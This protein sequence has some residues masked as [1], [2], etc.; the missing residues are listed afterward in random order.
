[1]A[2]TVQTRSRSDRYFGVGYIPGVGDTIGIG[3]E[4]AIP[5]YL[6][7]VSESNRAHPWNQYRSRNRSSVGQGISIG[8]GTENP[9]IPDP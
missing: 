4:S 3:S 6:E 1:M 5:G 7:S 2:G 8:I 9:G